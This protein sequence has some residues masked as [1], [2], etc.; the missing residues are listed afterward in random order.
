M[1]EPKGEMEEKLY[2]G[3]VGV[4]VCIQSLGQN[5]TPGAGESRLSGEPHVGVRR[6]RRWIFP[7]V[8]SISFPGPCILALLRFCIPRCLLIISG[9]VR[10][11]PLACAGGRPTYSILW[12]TWLTSKSAKPVEGTRCLRGWERAVPLLA[13]PFKNRRRA[14]SVM[15]RSA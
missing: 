2:P 1:R 3:L 14:L 12:G 6:C 9:G 13:N 4:Y 5:C 11:Q 8:S 10:W 7:A 15:R